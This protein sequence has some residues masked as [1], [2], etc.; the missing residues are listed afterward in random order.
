MN[1]R[2]ARAYT[3]ICEILKYL[4]KEEYERIPKEKIEFY[5]KNKDKDYI[6]V[7]DASKTLQEQNI[8]RETNAIIVTI[9]RDFFAT[10]VQKEKLQKILWKNEQKHQAELREKYDYNK[11]FDNKE[12]NIISEETKN[13]EDAKEEIVKENFA[14]KNEVEITSYNQS[15]FTKFKNWFYKLIHKSN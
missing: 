6:F 3:E 2:Y 7:F 13:K 1:N 15:I 11:L 10:D 14:T 4:P 9:F 12:K 5:E 8:S